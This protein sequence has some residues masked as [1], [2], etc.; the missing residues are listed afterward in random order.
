[1]IA[2]TFERLLYGL[3]NGRLNGHRRCRMVSHIGGRI[4]GA[5]PL[6]PDRHIW[7]VCQLSCILAAAGSVL[8]MVAF[9]C[10]A[11]SVKSSASQI[12]VVW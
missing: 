10:S 2:E 6:V 5:R 12:I 9:N 3:T 11:A 1:M 7:S 4:A 8:R